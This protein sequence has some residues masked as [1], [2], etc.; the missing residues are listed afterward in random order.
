[1][2]QSVITT[3]QALLAWMSISLQVLEPCVLS[4]IVR[5]RQK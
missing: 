1:L 2:Q 5:R 3:G 4:R